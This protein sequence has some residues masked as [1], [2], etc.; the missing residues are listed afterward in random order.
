[1]TFWV[2]SAKNFREQRNVWKGSPGRFPFNQNFRK[3]GI[4]GKWYRNFPKKYP[5]FRKLQKSRNANHST[6]NS[7]NPAIKVAW[8]ENLREKIFEN[9]GAPHDIVLFLEIFENAVPSRFLVDGTDFYNLYDS[10]RMKLI[11]KKED[12]LSRYAQ[13]FRKFFPGRFLSIQLCSQKFCNFCWIVRISEIQQF[14][15][16][17]ETFQG[18]F[19]TI[20]CCLQ[21]FESLGWMERPS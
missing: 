9:L 16:F 20:C 13:M 14:L 8:K 4:S 11:S 15:E 21:S 7:R 1:M 2:V 17:L 10:G 6:E 18:K 19:C 12:N 3:F 5:E